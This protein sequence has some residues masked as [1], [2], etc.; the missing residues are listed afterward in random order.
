MNLF[1]ENAQIENGSVSWHQEKYIC[2]MLDTLKAAQI[3]E[4]LCIL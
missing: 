4:I 2:N 3:S 1:L